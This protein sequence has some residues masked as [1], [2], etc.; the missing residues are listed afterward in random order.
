MN[1]VVS[2]VEALYSHFLLRD[3]AAKILPGLISLSVIL[4]FLFPDSY[5]VL[6]EVLG[7]SVFVGVVVL[8]GI[9]LVFGMLLQSVAASRGIIH[10]HVWL[11]NGKQNQTQSVNKAEEFLIAANV[12]APL[13]RKRERLA[14]LK[15]MAGNYFIAVLFLLIGL[16]AELALNPESRETQSYIGVV[17]LALILAA[18][19]WQNRHQARE[20]QEWEETTIQKFKPDHTAE[21]PA[22]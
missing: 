11:D 2:L 18:L 8:Y 13:L 6:Q 9:G 12:Y 3:I 16:F 5:V 20:Q 22:A 14:V 1:S 7:Y 17:T 10:I 15:E 4:I 19:F 21:T